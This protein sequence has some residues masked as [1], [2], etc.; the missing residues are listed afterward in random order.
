MSYNVMV[1]DNEP[2]IL[3]ALRDRFEAEGFYVATANGGQE[4][5]EEI[6]KGFRGVILMDIMMPKMNGW[7]TIREMVSRDLI[8]GNIIS[9][10]TASNAPGPEMEGLQQYV[11]DYIRKPFDVE[12]LVAIVK[13]YLEYLF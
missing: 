11:V 6:E 13:G 2:H 10:L 3:M 7:E 12:E 8:T 1:V 5:L 4:C 9:M